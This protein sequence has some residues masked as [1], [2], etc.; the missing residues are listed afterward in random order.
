MEKQALLAFLS[1]SVVD[2]ASNEHFRE[3]AATSGDMS[4]DW[5]DW[6]CPGFP[7]S[8]VN[9]YDNP[10]INPHD[11]YQS[12]CTPIVTYSECQLLIDGE[13][14][15]A[16]VYGT[17]F[18]HNSEKRP[19][20]DACKS[21]WGPCQQTGCLQGTRGKCYALCDRLNLVWPYADRCARECRAYCPEDAP[22]TP[23]PVLPPAPPPTPV[24]PYPPAPAPPQPPSPAPAPIPQGGCCSWAAP[25]QRQVCGDGTSWCKASPGNCGTCDGHWIYPSAV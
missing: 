17:I 9:Y 10:Q 6:E 20:Q 11:T 4:D 21:P 3:L 7:C 15:T 16:N 25:T 23:P 14:L 12:S 19:R 1:M 22:D 18:E 24:D 13:T 5:M 2:A 8:I